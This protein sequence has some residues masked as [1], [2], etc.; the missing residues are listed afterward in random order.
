MLL[1]RR[2]HLLFAGLVLSTLVTFF[3]A[4]PSAYAA[5]LL[6]QRQ[7]V[8]VC[9]KAYPNAR[10]SWASVV[11]RANFSSLRASVWLCDGGAPVMN[12]DA[13]QYCK[14]VKR[15]AKAV[16]TVVLKDRVWWLRWLG[17]EFAGYACERLGS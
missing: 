10:Y 13:D 16:L 1:R 5:D 14:S 11:P 9:N 2:L 12:S 4:V 7:M 6:Q 3:P 8:E 17:K 15:D